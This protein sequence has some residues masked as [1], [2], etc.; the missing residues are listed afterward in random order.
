MGFPVVC[1]EIFHGKCTDSARLTCIGRLC[2]YEITKRQK[3][4]F[5]AKTYAKL[6]FFTCI[7]YGVELQW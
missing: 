3:F 2:R 5:F 4:A 1:K 6:E 7:F